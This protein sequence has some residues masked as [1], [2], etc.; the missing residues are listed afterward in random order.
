MFL[1]KVAERTILTH[2][3]YISEFLYSAI[4]TVSQSHPMMISGLSLCLFL[5]IKTGNRE[6]V[7]CMTITGFALH[8]GRQKTDMPHCSALQYNLPGVSI[9]MTAPKRMG[10]HFWCIP[11]FL[12]QD[13]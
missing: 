1:T 5:F 4:T 7:Y 6:Y 10:Y 8:K 2:C 13:L 12:D 3:A 9:C 11:K